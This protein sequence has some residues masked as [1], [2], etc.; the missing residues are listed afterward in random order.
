MTPA[1]WK[2]FYANERR[3]LDLDA[4]V[5]SA[6]RIDFPE[7]LIF[8][9]TRL[10]VS[11]P[12][13]AACALAAAR[14]QKEI[15]AIGVLHGAPPGFGRGVHAIVPD[16]FS[17]DGFSAL[18]ARACALE[19]LTPKTIHTRFPSDAADPMLLDLSE[20]EM[21]SRS[22]AIVATTDPI[23]HGVGYGTEEALLPETSHAIAR[24][25]I[26]EQL[27]ALSN[28]DFPRFQ[29]LC[30]R[31]RSD[32]KNAG[33][34][35]AMLVPNMKHAIEALDLVDYSDVFGCARPTWVAG[36][37]ISVRRPS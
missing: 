20:L 25:R 13:V 37:T 17:L 4:I 1:E 18:Y 3:T 12:I 32:F 31:D 23:H 8:P 22:C 10:S 19:G 2:T 36:A 34:V 16:E 35:L 21:L 15:L 14:T 7:A 29:A 30:V 33:P 9:H 28:R 27:D 5:R 26:S 6:P 11:G 24:Q